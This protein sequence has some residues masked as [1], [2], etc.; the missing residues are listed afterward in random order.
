M[1]LFVMGSSLRP[2]YEP[3]RKVNAVTRRQAS[4]DASRQ[5]LGFKAEISLE[6]GLRSLVAWWHEQRSAARS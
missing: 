6:D 1:L 2:V 4:V 5:Q 3:P